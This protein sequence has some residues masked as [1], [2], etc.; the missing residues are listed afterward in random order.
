LDRKEE[1]EARKLEA[2]QMRFLR[3][4]LGL[5]RLYRQR[6]PDIRSILKMDNLVE[7]IKSYQKNCLDHLKWTEAAYQNWISST[8]LEDDGILE[9]LDEV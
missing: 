3:P 9:D 8:N 1:R 5:T 4:L 6:N 2:A 7:D